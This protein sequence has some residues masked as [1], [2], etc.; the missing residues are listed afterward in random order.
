MQVYR[1]V[2]KFL[3][4]KFLLLAEYGILGA[5]RRQKYAKASCMFE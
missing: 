3:I 2:S 5:L 1:A 4:E